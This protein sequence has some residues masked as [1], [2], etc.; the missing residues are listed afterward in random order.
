MAEN[1]KES[2]FTFDEIGAATLQ[3]TW[4]GMLYGVGGTGKTGIAKNAPGAFFIAL[5]DGVEWTKAPTFLRGG[6]TIIPT[7][8]QTIM[9][10]IKYIRSNKQ[11][12]FDKGIKTIVIDNLTFFQD[13]VFNDIIQNHST[14]TEKGQQLKTTC[15]TD[16]GYNGTCYVMPYF[17]RIITGCLALKKAGFNVL[18]LSHASLVNS[19]NNDDGKECKK[20]E[21]G[22]QTHGNNNVPD[23]FKRSCDFIYY[24]NSESMTSTT[25]S[26]KWSKTLGVAFPCDIKIN[27]RATSLF[28][29]KS[30]VA[31]LSAIP[32][33]YSFKLNECDDGAK[34]MF[35]DIQM[36]NK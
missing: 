34:Q 14:Y 10:M 19:V 31:D 26:G 23:L 6:K 24:V 2:N 27:T 20:F 4:F 21:I 22:L 15:L 12:F 8:Y 5:E 33:Q 11:Q 16:L 30:R 17:N 1:K 29:A 25:G 32:N 36:A 35:L 13:L 9:D 7:N 3:T 18:V 28:Y